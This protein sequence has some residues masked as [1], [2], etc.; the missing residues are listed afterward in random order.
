MLNDKNLQE[1]MRT[2]L[3]DRLPDVELQT[4]LTEPAIDSEGEDSLRITLVIPENSV[5]KISGDQALDLISDVQRALSA[6]GDNRLAVISYATPADL[7]EKAAFEA[8][9]SQDEEDD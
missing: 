1:I 5:E 8:E 9:S 6:K 7:V 4:I 3:H 2:I